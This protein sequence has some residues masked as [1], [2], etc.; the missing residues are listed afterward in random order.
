[1]LSW[2][3]LS[4]CLSTWTSQY[5]VGSFSNILFVSRLSGSS[6]LVSTKLKFLTSIQHGGLYCNSDGTVSK[7]IK[8]NPYCADGVGSVSVVNKMSGQHAVCQT[9]LPGNEAML[10]PTS[11]GS[12][13]TAAIAV[14]GTNYW[15]STAAHVSLLY[16]TMYGAF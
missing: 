6:S 1:M 4:L 14:P 13:S 2:Q 7:P 12:G 3:L 10:I 11:V 5:A 16:H 9:V 15:A 8:G